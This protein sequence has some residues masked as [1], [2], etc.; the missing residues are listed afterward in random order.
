M[1]FAELGI[2][3]RAPTQNVPRLWVQSHRSEVPDCG[4]AHSYCIHEDDC[5]VLSV[6]SDLTQHWPAWPEDL[7]PACLHRLWVMR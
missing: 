1:I 3:V 5:R 7:T 4:S 6:T 2:R